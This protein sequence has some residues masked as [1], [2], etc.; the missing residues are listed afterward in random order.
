MFISFFCETLVS[1]KAEMTMW[2]CVRNISTLHAHSV[3][4]TGCICHLDPRKAFDFNVK[5]FQ[6]QNS[7]HCKIVHT[8]VLQLF[9]A[10]TCLSNTYTFLVKIKILL[11][12]SCLTYSASFTSQTSLFYIADIFSF[13]LVNI[14]CMNYCI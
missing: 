7:L 14:R 2:S 5:V 4:K 13:S 3:A 1:L 8:N 11:F 12:F 9:L 6:C 10:I